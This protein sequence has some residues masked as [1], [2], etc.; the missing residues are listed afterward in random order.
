[1]STNQAL[2]R[3]GLLVSGAFLVSRL[4]GWVRVVVIGNAF[5]ASAELDAF[6]AAFRIPDLL[7]QLVAAGA[8]STALI[9]LLA[10]LF[11]TQER[12]RAWRVVS[13][14]ANLILIALLALALVVFAAA[15]ALV[16]GVIAPG[17]TPARQALTVDLTRIMLLSA[18]FLALGS[19]ATSVL[20]AERRF[21]AAA[22]APIV[23]NL[24]II[25]AAI[26]LAPSLGVTG[27]AIGVVL[28]ALGHLAIQF[29]PV[30][31]LG[32]RW[33]AAIDLADPAAR[34]ALRLMAPRAI[35]LG[36]SQITFVVVTALATGLGVGAVTAFTIAFTL[37]QIPIGVIG[38]PLGVVLFP[39]LSHEIATG[40]REAFVG[41]L[42]RAMR[43][44]VFVMIPVAALTAILRTEGVALLFG[45][46]SADAVALTAATLLAF[47]I[48]LVAH[49][50]IAVLARAFYARQDTVTPVIAAVG[51]VVV[52]TTLAALLVGPYGLP[53]I[54]LAIA[55][56]AWLEA[57]VL[58]ILLERRVDGL[59][60]VGVGSVAV[61]T[62]IATV[63]AGA[64]GL[65]VRALVADALL[66]PPIVGGV[67][68]IV[69][70]AATLLIV[71]AAFGGAF[72]LAALALRITEGPSIVALM[73]DALRRPRRS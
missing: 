6:Y 41:L 36:A 9:P 27:V 44:I 66:P 16:A 55:I 69:P 10:E 31:A 39:S 61:R 56:A 37:L 43:A 60:L 64:V 17:F 54:A 53:G 35:G 24:A 38:V 63:V 51:A 34:R 67:G 70:L 30:R 3:A 25:G 11:A 71:T 62:A 58:V 29:V 15:P 49:A 21:A 42:T 73:L 40:D 2:A 52:N 22:I 12:A 59:S 1:M 47:T 19:V 57:G 46:F 48:G 4:L 18:T 68:A 33:V 72:V 7:F 45:R 14:V 28:G 32:F 13:T 23:Y 65:G 5:G 8:L 26:L 20:N 50:L